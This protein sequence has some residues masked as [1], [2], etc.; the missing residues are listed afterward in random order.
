MHIGM[1]LQLQQRNL[2]YGGSVIRIPIRV[3]FEDIRVAVVQIQ[4]PLKKCYQFLAN[5]LMDARL[6]ILGMCQGRSYCRD[7]L[8]RNEKRASALTD[9]RIYND[10]LK[11]L[12]ENLNYV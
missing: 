7:F 1:W 11:R 12:N 9:Y 8:Q 10:S 6:Y 2:R 5:I 4:Y 3:I